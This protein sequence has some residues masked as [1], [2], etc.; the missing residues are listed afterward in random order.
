M[1]VG[2]IETMGVAADVEVTVKS[3][4]AEILNTGGMPA[5]RRTA[6]V[7]VVATTIFFSFVGVLAAGVGLEVLDGAAELEG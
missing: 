3:I 4:G 7:E 1:L 6:P 2:S 5:V